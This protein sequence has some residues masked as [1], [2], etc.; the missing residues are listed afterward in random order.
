MTYPWLRVDLLVDGHVLQLT[1]NATVAAGREAPVEALSVPLH[2]LPRLLQG[3]QLTSPGLFHAGRKAQLQ[4]LH[5]V[6]A[7]VLAGVVVKTGDGLHRRVGIV[8]VDEDD[9]RA[10]GG[11]P[12]KG[13]NAGEVAEAAEATLQVGQRHVG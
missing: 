9:V 6:G 8:V 11:T 1:A 5:R 7:Q 2:Q 4:R 13:L 3:G 12:L 10:I